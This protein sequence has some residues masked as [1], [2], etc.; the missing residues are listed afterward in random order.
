VSPFPYFRTTVTKQNLIQE[1]IKRR[2][3]SSNACY[4]SVQNLLSPHLLSKDIKN[5]ICK[6]ITLPLVLYGCE[7]WFLTLREEHIL[8]VFE[9][10]ELRRI[11]RPKREEVTGGWRKLH[12]E[13]LRDFYSLPS[14]IKIIK[15]NLLSSI[16]VILFNKKIIKLQPY[17]TL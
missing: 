17:S 11:F 12:N 14:I 7:T 13:E 10:R 5:R 3:N 8:R 9:N 6:T 16:N 2:F 1:K 15:S 4:H